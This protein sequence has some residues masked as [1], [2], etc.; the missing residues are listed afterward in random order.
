V[1]QITVKDRY[2][3]AADD[4]LERDWLGAWE[5]MTP[6]EVYQVARGAWR[7]NP[8]NFP[9]FNP[10]G[11]R[12]AL[13]VWRDLVIGA[14]TVEDVL[15]VEPPR[16]RALVGTPLHPGDEEYDQYVGKP[17]YGRYRNPIRYVGRPS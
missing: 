14:F 5:G 3:A 1:I 8:A 7:L 16:R 10:D 11:H 4:P 13:V 15:L 9:P 2:E 17:P 12:L 6:E